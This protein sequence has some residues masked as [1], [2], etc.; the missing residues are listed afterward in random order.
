MPMSVP[1]NRR[2][3]AAGSGGFTLIELLL[4]IAI[5]AMAGAGV[6]FALR[7][8][9]QAQLEREAQRLVA[10]LESA[11]A[12]SRASGQP[13]YWQAT[14]QG[15]EFVGLPPKRTNGDGGAE[16]M[17][18][19]GQALP[20]LWLA[21]GT[22]VREAT[23]VTLGPEPIIGRQQIT[24]LQADRRLRIATD[25]LRPFAF[26]PVSADGAGGTSP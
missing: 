24:L 7:G 9:G 4:V 16:A 25:G 17:D 11:R 23:T 10:L 22:S 15:F 1:G 2:V 14:T 12:Q 20:T 19:A 6:G 5:I 8:Q 21:E 26:Q 3:A 18:S 13:V